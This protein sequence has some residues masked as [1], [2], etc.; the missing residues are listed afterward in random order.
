M[1]EEEFLFWLDERFD[2]DE[3]VAEAQKKAQEQ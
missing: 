2:Y 3:H 1:S